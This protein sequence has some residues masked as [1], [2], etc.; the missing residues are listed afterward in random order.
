MKGR[1]P[2]PKCEE[3]VDAVPGSKPHCGD[4]TLAAASDLCSALLDVARNIAA[5]LRFLPKHDEK[6]LSKHGGKDARKAHD[7]G[8]QER[9]EEVETEAR[10]DN[11]DL[12]TKLLAIS[13]FRLV[14][15][16]KHRLPT[17]FHAPDGRWWLGLRRGQPSPKFGFDNLSSELGHDIVAAH[18]DEVVCDSSAGR[19][20]HFQ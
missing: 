16:G 17:K 9:A 14:L 6:S 3:W 8:P 12:P 5:L 4:E 2:I 20:R 15:L 7:Y 10:W 11:K 1:S 19:R 18:C 13:D